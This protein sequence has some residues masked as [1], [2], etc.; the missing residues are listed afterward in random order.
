[1]ISEPVENFALCDVFLLFQWLIFTKKNLNLKDREKT[2]YLDFLKKQ[3]APILNNKY[4]GLYKKTTFGKI[5]V[6]RK[7][8]N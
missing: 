8:L 5:L 7:C 3:A 1:M 4:T 2:R 6:P